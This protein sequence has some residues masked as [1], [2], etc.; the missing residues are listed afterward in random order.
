MQ[1]ACGM[2]EPEI[3]RGLRERY[4]AGARAMPGRLSDL[5]RKIQHPNG[6]CEEDWPMTKPD[7][8]RANA[9]ECERMAASS[10]NPNQKAK[11]LQMA[12]QWLRMIP[13][14]GSKP[15][16]FDFGNALIRETKS[17]E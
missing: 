6:L 7:E 15:D 1:T 9:Q 3:G 12:Q 13:K 16:Q 8:Y 17:E 14:V 5:L 2:C 10:R 11:W 4:D